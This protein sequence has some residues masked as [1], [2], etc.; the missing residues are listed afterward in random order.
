M[1]DIAPVA[2]DPDAIADALD[3]LADETGKASYRYAAKLARGETGGGR[4]PHDDSAALRDVRALL[5]SG[6]IADAGKACK[7][8]AKLRAPRTE[9]RKR[10]RRLMDKLQK[11]VR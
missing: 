2:I 1:D 7:A 5:A 4:R 6:T 9:R 10:I 8:V 11:V 3:A